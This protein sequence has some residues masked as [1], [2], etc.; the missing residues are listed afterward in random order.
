V[1]QTDRTLW[2]LQNDSHAIHCVIR[3]CCAGAELQIVKTGNG[4]EESTIVARELYPSK[5]DLY[6]RSRMLE[7][8][9]RAEAA[10]R[11]PDVRPAEPNRG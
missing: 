7:R 1:D 9:Y 2:T 3:S 8:Q 6:E 5:S 11:P 4:A 10:R